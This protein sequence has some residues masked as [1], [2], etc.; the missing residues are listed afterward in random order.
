MPG[1][2]GLVGNTC[3]AA[4]LPRML[5]RLRHQPWYTR[6]SWVDA[7]GGAALGRVGLGYVNAAPQ[8]A[9]NE[10]GSQRAVLEGEIYDYATLR[11]E[12]EAKGHR[13]RGDG[14]AELLLQGWEADG[15]AF[16]RRLNGCF[17]AAI[18]DDRANTLTLLN[19]RFGMRALY[20][21]HS[22]GRILFGSEIK[23]LFVDPDLYRS[24]D[25]RGLAQFFT[26][27]QYL[28]RT[29]SFAAV[30]LLPAAGILTYHVE[31]DGVELHRYA[32]LGESWQSNGASHS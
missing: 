3:D 19:D 21:S 31:D 18:W 25:P 24:T 28:G 17:S 6:D 9:V 14:Y 2:A 20:Y 7:S 32:R 16:V 4:L 26:F 8:P 23:A 22:P 5:A 27:G 30:S 29:T 1:I 13:F 10:D 11:R 12:L 15:A